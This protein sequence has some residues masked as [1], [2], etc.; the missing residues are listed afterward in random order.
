MFLVF[1]IN[2][3]THL[4]SV[5]MEKQKIVEIMTHQMVYVKIASQDINL[6]N[7]LIAILSLLSVAYQILSNRSMK[8]KEE[9]VKK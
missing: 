6:M 5:S 1:K 7:H 3:E 4:G 8:S 2:I 9:N